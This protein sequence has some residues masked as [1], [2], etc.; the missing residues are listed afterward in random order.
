MSQGFS[1]NTPIFTTLAPAKIN[2]C[3]DIIE[4]DSSSYHKIQTV[5]FEEKS[6]QN[7]LRFFENPENLN[8][9]ISEDDDNLSSQAL[10]LVKKKFDIKQ[11]I[12]IEII[13][14]IP[15][16]SGLGG[17]SSNAAATLKALNKIWQLGLSSD[18]LREIAQELGMDVPFFIDGR[19]ALATNFGEQITQLP[20]INDLH[21]HLFP[22][23]KELHDKTAQAFKQIDLS[24]CGKNLAKSEKLI[25]AIKSGNNSAIIENLH[26]DFEML[27]P[28]LPANHHLSGSGPSTFS[29]HI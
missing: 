8:M 20:D 28:K 16:S 23:S 7:E 6:L 11:N 13:Q 18:Q 4:K 9:S 14:N 2:L 12:Y 27:Y 5:L 10:R 3:L 29:V 25:A 17:S 19:T 24:R 21:F 15:Y 26:N 1:P 22:Q